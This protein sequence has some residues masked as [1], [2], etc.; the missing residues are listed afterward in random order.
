MFALG[1]LGFRVYSF[2]VGFRAR[3]F[4]GGGGVSS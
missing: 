1:G 3:G 4:G 2:W